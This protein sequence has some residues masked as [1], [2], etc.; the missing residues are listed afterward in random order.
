[1]NE[2]ELIKYFEELI[3]WIDENCFNDET[4]LILKAK[5]YFEINKLKRKIKLGKKRL[6]YDNCFDIKKDYLSNS[7]EEI[8]QL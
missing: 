8:K 1:M 6:K 3:L 5:L 7:L 4:K 2:K